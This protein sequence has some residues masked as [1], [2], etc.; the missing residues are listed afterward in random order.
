MLN[1]LK[2]KQGRK[3]Q[4]IDNSDTVLCRNRPKEIDAFRIVW[5][6]ELLTSFFYLVPMSLIVVYLYQKSSI[7][8]VDSAMLLFLM[9]FTARLGRLLL[10]PVLD[11]IPV[12]I[13]LSSMQLVCAIGFFLLAKTEIFVLLVVSVLLI[14]FFYG[15]SVLVIRAVVSCLKIE[16][17]NQRIMSFARLN[18]ATNI[19][20]LVGPFALNQ[21][22]NFSPTGAFL[23]LSLLALL[24]A[25]FTWS[26]TKDINIPQQSHWLDNFLFLMKMKVTQRAMLAVCLTWFLYAFAMTLFPLFLIRIIGDSHYTWTFI[27]L[28]GVMTICSS[29]WIHNQLRHYKVS[30][31]KAIFLSYGLFLIAIA[32]LLLG[33]LN[34]VLFFSTVIIVTIAEV[35][36][37]PNCSALLSKTVPEDKRVS[38]FAL[39]AVGIGLGEAIGNSF[40][41]YVFHRV[42]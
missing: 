1:L 12:Y 29:V 15:N 4:E 13:L 27:S 40:A 38:V 14:G 22:Y 6:E 8:P 34:L 33:D 30:G 21:I 9:A 11:K 24:A 10:T 36:A 17:E 32:Y 39:Y 26:L 35:V 28:N 5:V 2:Y 31:F 20:I 42:V 37:I 25:F 19:P 3:E 16:Q 7:T 41:F 18:I 23:T